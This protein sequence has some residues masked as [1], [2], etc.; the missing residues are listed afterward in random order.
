MRVLEELL[1]GLRRVCASFPDERQWR[2]DNIAIADAGLAA[3]SLFFMQSE[4][5]LAHQRRM[6]HGRNASN[7]K[8]LFGIEK[9][10][11]GNHIRDLLDPALAEAVLATGA[12]FL[13]VCKKD[14]HKTL[15]VALGKARKRGN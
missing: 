14:S 8:T 6:E 11:S 4:S 1:G 12:D 9:I 7:C 2:P 5:F 10:P 13:F 15:Y 3:F